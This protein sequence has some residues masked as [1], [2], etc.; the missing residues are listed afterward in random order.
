[1][2]RFKNSHEAE[3]IVAFHDEEKAFNYFIK[4][5]WADSFTQ[6][7]DLFELT[8]DLANCFML[9]TETWNN[10]LKTFTRWVEAYG[11]F[12]YNSET[13]VYTLTEAGSEYSGVITVEV[14]STLE[15]YY[16]E[17]QD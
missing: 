6:Y 1:M 8:K 14:E 13:D 10:D 16:T 11:T 4:G 15:V 17:I 7:D 2:K 5:D 12:A 9:A 3:T